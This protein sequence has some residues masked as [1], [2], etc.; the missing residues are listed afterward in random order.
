LSLSIP[1]WPL[2]VW[3]PLIIFV[4]PYVGLLIVV[5]SGLVTKYL[6]I[7]P[8][9][10]WWVMFKSVTTWTKPTTTIRSMQQNQIKKQV[11]DIIR[12]TSDVD[13]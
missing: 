13:D 1:D 12:K 7:F 8:L 4:T 9:M 11:D 2:L 5:F 6:F 3:I 10:W